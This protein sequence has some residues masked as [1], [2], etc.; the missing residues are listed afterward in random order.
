MNLLKR[1]PGNMVITAPVIAAS[2]YGL[3]PWLGLWRS[4]GIGVCL[5]LLALEYRR[6]RQE[7]RAEKNKRIPR[8]RNPAD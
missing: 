8:P 2:V 1:I 5:G 3:S 7:L 6:H 4:C